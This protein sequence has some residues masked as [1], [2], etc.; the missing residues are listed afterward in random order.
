M[1]N[2]TDSTVLVTGAA[3]GLGAALAVRF[4]EA[5]ANTVVAARHGFD[6][7]AAKHPDRR[8]PAGARHQPHRRTARYP[9]CGPVDA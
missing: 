3:G 5:G 6:E 1:F 2:F 7:L 8:I 4:A 9:R